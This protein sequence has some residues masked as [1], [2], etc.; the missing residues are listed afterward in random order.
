MN[1]ILRLK[2][3]E[4]AENTRNMALEARSNHLTSPPKERYS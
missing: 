1:T 3:A 4:I 2:P